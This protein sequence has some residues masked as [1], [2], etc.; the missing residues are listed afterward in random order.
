M[1][2]KIYYVMDVMCGWCY[3]F[4]DVIS[5]IQEKYK[6]DYDFNIVPGGMWVGDNVKTMDIS[7]GSYIKGHNSKIETMTGKRFGEG[8]NK[9]V[10]E[11]SN[12]VL[13]SLPGSKALVLIQKLKKEVAFSYL[14]KVQEAL[15]I[16]GR[17]TNDINLYTELAESFGISKDLFEK[18]M[19]SK[20]L[21]KE[22]YNTFNSVFSLGVNSFPTVVAV[23][24]NK[25]QI[26]SQGYS[27]FE[28][29]D[30]ILSS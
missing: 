30:S 18:E 17:D 2:T 26:I 7:L 4:S 1:K 20:E 27:S 11:G 8:F 6:D 10:L 19:L 12:R 14:K 9:N 15:F 5:K 21:E 24:G 29:L 13:D 23:V 25:S 16:E 3:G 28:E 22:T